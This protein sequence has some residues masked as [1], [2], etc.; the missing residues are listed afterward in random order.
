MK[1]TGL[2]VFLVEIPLNEPYMEVGP[3][4]PELEP[5]LKKTVDFAMAR[6]LTDEGLEGVGAQVWGTSPEW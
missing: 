2:E 6:V 5:V 3:I 1:I 4:H